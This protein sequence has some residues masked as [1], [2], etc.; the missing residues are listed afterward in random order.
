MQ[1]EPPQA[2][3]LCQGR[4]VWCPPQTHVPRQLMA[5]SFP[6]ENLSLDLCASW[7]ACSRGCTEQTNPKHS[8][9]KISL[10]CIAKHPNTEAQPLGEIMSWSSSAEHSRIFFQKGYPTAQHTGLFAR[11]SIGNE[12]CNEPPCSYTQELSN[13]RKCE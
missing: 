6:G 5:F 3:P 4:R 11:D 13:K 9:L 8:K 10:Q 12:P 7:K 1:R 2:G